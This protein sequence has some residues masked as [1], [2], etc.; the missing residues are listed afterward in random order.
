MKKPIRCVLWNKKDLISKDLNYTNFELVETLE[1][2]SHF[3]RRLM[4]CKECGQLYFKEFYEEIDWI[5]GDDPQY[6]TYIP[7]ETKEEIDML[8]KTSIFELLQYYPRIQD[9]FPK[10]VKEAT[11]RWVLE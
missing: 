7:V 2:E 6:S 9:D 5:D 10:G 11:V 8:K 3:S 1:E 4:K